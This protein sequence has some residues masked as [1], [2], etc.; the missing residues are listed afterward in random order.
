MTPL[1]AVKCAN[2]A[3]LKDGEFAANQQGFEYHPLGNQSACGW[4][5][6]KGDKTVVAIRGTVIAADRGQNYGPNFQTDLVPWM[7]PGLVHEGYYTALWHLMGDLKRHL[8]GREEVYFTGHSMG[9][10]IALLGAALFR[11]VRVFCFASPRVGNK[12]FADITG[13]LIRVT[14]YEN[15]GDFLTKFPLSGL[16]KGGRR[17]IKENYCH[18][19]RVVRLPRLGHGMSAYVTGIEEKQRKHEAFF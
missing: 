12:T 8:T 7:G 19:G 18:V 15:R 17:R 4:V 9:A 16:V 2:I 14:R 6:H 11:C 10:A 1:T 3:Y 5:G 13:E